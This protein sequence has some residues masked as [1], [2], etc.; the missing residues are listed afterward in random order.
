SRKAADLVG[1]T[2]MDRPED[3]EV[4]PVNG[5]VYAMLTNN[6]RRTPEQIDAVN[7]RAANGF[8]QIVELWPE[9]GDHTRDTFQ[10][11]LFLLGGNPETV[12][13]TSYHPGIS[14]NGWLSSPDNCAFDNLGNIWI[15]T[16]GAENSG[17]AE[18]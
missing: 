5:K 13:F 3:V 14:A 11:E 15:A 2:E 17:V 1:A 6:S 16:D 4:N 9:D 7:P 12:E 8:G 10:W 18:G